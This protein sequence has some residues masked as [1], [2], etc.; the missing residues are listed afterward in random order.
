MILRKDDNVELDFGL[1]A[2][3]L[4]DAIPTEVR[5][6][7]RRKDKTPLQGAT[8]TIANAFSKGLVTKARTDRAGRYQANVNYPGQY[9]VYASKPEFIVS[10]TTIVLPASLPRKSRMVDLVLVRPANGSIYGVSR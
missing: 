7:V 10:A 3:Y 9:I 8:V 5:G 1:V 6:A 4:G 2:G